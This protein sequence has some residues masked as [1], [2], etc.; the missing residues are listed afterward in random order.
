M[1]NRASLTRSVKSGHCQQD[2]SEIAKESGQRLAS[3]V[4]HILPYLGWNGCARIGEQ[5]RL[6]VLNYDK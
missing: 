1:V 3:E 4:Q 5:T 6:S 2:G